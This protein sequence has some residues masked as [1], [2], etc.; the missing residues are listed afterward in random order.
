MSRLQAV[1]YLA[2]AMVGFAI[3]SLIC[4][5]VMVYVFKELNKRR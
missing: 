1:I 5:R 2:L 3:F 4:Y